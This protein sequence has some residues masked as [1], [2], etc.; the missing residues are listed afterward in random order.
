[1]KELIKDIK[2]QLQ[3]YSFGMKALM[4]LVAMKQPLMRRK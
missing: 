3:G 1:M 2:K 4:I